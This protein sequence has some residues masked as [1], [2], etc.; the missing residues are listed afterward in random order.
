MIFF[1]MPKEKAA[2]KCLLLVSACRTDLL[3]RVRMIT[4]VIGL[5]GHGHG[6]GRKVLDLFELEA[7]FFGFSGKVG[8]IL[9]VAAGVAGDEIGDELLV[10]LFAF[11][12]G[13][14]SG[15]ELVEK[16]ERRFSHHLEDVVG[17]MFGGDL[18]AA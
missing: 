9:E 13:V 16:L 6:G 17:G 8:H 14:E 18:E 4:R 7:E 15:F 10:D 2:L 11:T 12:D 1:L 5:G 3:E